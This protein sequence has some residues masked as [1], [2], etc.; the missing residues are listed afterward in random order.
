[1]VDTHV[2][3]L[4][5]TASALPV[6]RRLAVIT[7]CVAALH[8]AALWALQ[9]GLWRQPVEM[10]IPVTLSA[11]VISSPSTPASPVP[12]PATPA[13]PLRSVPSFAPATPL[14]PA[15]VPSPVPTPVSPALPATN[16][17]VTAVTAPSTPAGASTGRADAQAAPSATAAGVSTGRVELPTSDADY[18][19][20]PKPTYPPQSRRL[21]E[22]GKV[23]VR[24]F[25][26]ADGLPQKAQILQ[27]SGYERL[28]QAALTTV[29]KWRY[30][31]GKRGGKPEAMWFNV[32][33]NFVLE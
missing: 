14:P 25:I 9:A 24:V 21:N 16:A 20:N 5:P 15:V 30:V 13:S 32:P 7:V 31:P 4:V 22:Q 2:N 6:P 23:V 29:L 27:S 26:G 17:Q 12:V 8:A 10:L 1:M 19:Q 28:D 33:I 18:L 3:W 11:E